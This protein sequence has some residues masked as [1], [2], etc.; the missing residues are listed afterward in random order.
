M[1]D[2]SNS[3]TPVY[4]ERE[5]QLARVQG[6]KGN[7]SVRFKSSMSVDELP[8][9]RQVANRIRDAY[10]LTEAEQILDWFINQYVTKRQIEELER[11]DSHYWGDDDK[12]DLVDSLIGE[13]LADRIKKLEKQLEEWKSE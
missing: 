12:D 6:S 9:K 4:S 2:T 3:R 13:H 5:H 8:D 11:L 7:E 1:T 10:T